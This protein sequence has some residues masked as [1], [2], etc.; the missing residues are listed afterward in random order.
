V[1]SDN[2]SEVVWA[3]SSELVRWTLNGLNI[4]NVQTFS[5]PLARFLFSFSA[6]LLPDIRGLLDGGSCYDIL[7]F[8]PSVGGVRIEEGA[9]VDGGGGCR[10]SRSFVFSVP[11]WSLVSGNGRYFSSIPGSTRNPLFRDAQGN[12]VTWDLTVAGVPIPKFLGTVPR[13]WTIIDGKGDYDG[14]GRSEI[15]W[16]HENGV[17]AYWKLSTSGQVSGLVWVGAAPR[18]EWTLVSGSGDYDGDGRSDLLFINAQGAIVAWFMNGDN[19]PFTARTLGT[20]GPGW[21]VLSGH[22]DFNGDGKGDILFRNSA[23]QV[24]IWLVGGREGIL[25]GRTLG[26]VGLDWRFVAQR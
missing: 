4:T 17:V 25:S 5:E 7:Y 11:G 18:S 19:V 21:T 1:D 23:G 12:V 20:A 26:P 22:E 24:A 14:D 13:E 16:Q 6:E 10:R 15:L 3:S 2:R 8:K 9:V